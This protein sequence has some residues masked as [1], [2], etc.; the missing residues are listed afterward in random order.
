MVPVDARWRFERAPQKI[1]TVKIQTPPF[2][3]SRLVSQVRDERRGLASRQRK[4]MVAAYKLM[5]RCAGSQYI[6]W[7]MNDY[8]RNFGQGKGSE[9][10]MILSISSNII[11]VAPQLEIGPIIPAMGSTAP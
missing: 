1:T 11:T 8:I 9:T 6:M 4:C 3:V 10:R 5:E 7:I 2:I